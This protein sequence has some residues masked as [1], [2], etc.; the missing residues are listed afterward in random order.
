MG[1][2]STFRHFESPLSCR[3]MEGT[4]SRVFRLHSHLANA[5]HTH[6]SHR[7]HPHESS[8]L[9][10]P[11]LPRQRIP[12]PL[13]SAVA[14]H[15]LSQTQPSLNSPTAEG[16]PHSAPRKRL[17]PGLRLP[18]TSTVLTLPY[19]VYGVRRLDAAFPKPHHP[20]PA[21][22]PKAGHRPQPSSSTDW[23]PPPRF[24]RRILSVRD[25]VHLVAF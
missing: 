16:R 6:S 4:H 9:R 8:S 23:L 2:K 5:A 25:Q 11:T 20:S 19:A 17:A 18:A 12:T 3:S 15:R 21:S 24:T 10:D 13:W 14:R 22:R 7:A 1:L